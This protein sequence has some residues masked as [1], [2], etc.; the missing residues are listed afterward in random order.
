MKEYDII[1][2]WPELMGKAVAHRT[3]EIHIK[4]QTLY[5]KIDS[6]VMREELLLGKQIIIDRLNDY[7]G[8][9][10]VTDIWFA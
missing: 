7:A 1:A 10:I 2:A 9:E 5:L 4:H 8:Q 6:S 3:K